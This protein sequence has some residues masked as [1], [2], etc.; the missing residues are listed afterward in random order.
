MRF[1][2]FALVIMA[3]QPIFSYFNRMIRINK[4][5]SEIGYCSRREADK[6]IQA[7]RVL[8]NDFTAIDGNDVSP[9]DEVM[10]DFEVVNPKTTSKPVYIAF[11]KPKGLVCTTD[12][13]LEKNNIVDYIRHQKR[14]FPI[15]RLDKLSEG[16]IFLTND[17]DI[18]NKI[19]RAE[20]RHEKEYQVE[21]NKVITPEF[22]NRMASGIPILGTYTKRCEVKQ[23]G[24]Q[25]FT[26]ILT[27]GLNRQIRRMCEYLTYRVT[28]LIRIRIMSIK[29]D[30]PIGHYRDLSPE[31][32]VSIN[33]SISGSIKAPKTKSK[34]SDSPSKAKEPFAKT[35]SDKKTGTAKKPFTK[36]KAR[37]DATKSS[38]PKK[39]RRPAFGAKST[40]SRRD[41]AARKEA[42]NR[43]K[44]DQD[45]QNATASAA[46]GATT[47]RMK[48]TI[49]EI[50]IPGHKPR[51]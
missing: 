49:T 24:K 44:I 20:N 2:G 34:R 42:D 6:L 22:I 48:R 17:G 14:I 13:K 18:V 31:E 51:K 35:G 25:S 45:L 15:G 33:A 4:Y 10:V 46:T 21:V 40:G 38:E 43:K 50:K 39:A 9:G 23:T 7:G 28:K 26:I 19:L 32:M 30:L 36:G 47:K 3:L 27:Q 16:L 37:P 12:T 1:C 8:I 11:N 41:V 29:L 5:L